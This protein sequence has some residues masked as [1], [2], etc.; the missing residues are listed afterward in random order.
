MAIT[1]LL[2]KVDPE[3]IPVFLRDKFYEL[4]VEPKYAETDY[5]KMEDTYVGWVFIK[6]DGT[7]EFGEPGV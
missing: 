4:H 5:A 6:S 7:I 2:L 1:N 3:Q